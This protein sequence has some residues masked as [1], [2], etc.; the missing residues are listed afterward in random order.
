MQYITEK[1]L[2]NIRFVYI[3][4]IPISTLNSQLKKETHYMAAIQLNTPNIL[5]DILHR[6]V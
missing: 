4:Q 1:I 5:E 3:A 6:A 2:N